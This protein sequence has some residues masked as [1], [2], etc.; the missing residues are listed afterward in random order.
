MYRIELKKR[1]KKTDKSAKG[2]YKYISRSELSNKDMVKSTDIE[3]TFSKVPKLFEEKV[4]NFWN[5]VDKNERK[6][7][8]VNSELLISIPREFDKEERI[9]LVDNLIKEILDKNTP[10][11]YAIH[12]PIASDGLHNPHCHLMIYEKNLNRSFFKENFSEDIDNK[13]FKG[14][15][16]KDENYIKKNLNYEK[17]SFIYDSREKFEEQLLTMS[18]STTKDEIINSLEISKELKEIGDKNKKINQKDY[19]QFIKAEQILMEKKRGNYMEEFK[20]IINNSDKIDIIKDFKT[21]IDNLDNTEFE[22]MMLLFSKEKEFFKDIRNL[23]EE[24]LVKKNYDDTIKEILSG[25]TDIKAIQNE[26]T[27][28]SKESDLLKI[29]KNIRETTNVTDITDKYIYDQVITQIFKGN[30]NENDDTNINVLNLDVPRYNEINFFL[31]NLKNEFQLN[32]KDYISETK[33]NISIDDNETSSS[34]EVGCKQLDKEKHE[35]ACINLEKGFNSKEKEFFSNDILR[36]QLRLFYYEFL[37]YSDENEENLEKE[38]SIGYTEFYNNLETNIANEYMELTKSFVYTNL[39]YKMD[40][41]YFSLKDEEDKDK[42]SKSNKKEK[43]TTL[44]NVDYDFLNPI[45]KKKNL[46][47]KSF[48]PDLSKKINENIIDLLDNEEKE[49]TNI[50]NNSLYK[51]SQR[52]DYVNKVKSILAK[53]VGY[54]NQ[55][56]EFYK[57]NI[58]NQALK[59]REKIL[60]TA[61]LVEEENGVRKN[62]INFKV[63]VKSNGKEQEKTYTDFVNDVIK[64]DKKNL[65]KNLNGTFIEKGSITDKKNFSDVLIKD[66]LRPNLPLLK[67]KKYLIK[68]VNFGNMREIK[69]ENKENLITL[70]NKKETYYQYKLKKN[71]FTS[72]SVL[73]TSYN[74]ALE[75]QSNINLNKDINHLILLSLDK[76]KDDRLVLSN[77]KL[78]KAKKYNL[79]DLKEIESFIGKVDKN[80]VLKIS[81]NISDKIYDKNY[82]HKELAKEFDTKKRI[83]EKVK[84]KDALSYMGYSD[85][86]EKINNTLKEFEYNDKK[87]LK[88]SKLK[89]FTDVNEM[90]KLNTLGTYKIN[91]NDENDENSDKKNKIN[92][93]EIIGKFFNWYTVKGYKISERVKNTDVNNFDTIITDKNLKSEN[94]NIKNF[95]FSVVI[96]KKNKVSITDDMKKFEEKKEEIYVYKKKEVLAFQLE[97]A[98]KNLSVANINGEE[99]QTLSEVDSLSKK[100]L[101]FMKKSIEK[102]NFDKSKSEEILDLEKNVIKYEENNKIKIEK[103]K[104]IE[105]DYYNDTSL[106]KLTEYVKQKKML[107]VSLEWEQTQTT[108]GKIE[109]KSKAI[110]FQGKDLY[111][112]NN[113]IFFDNPKMEDERLYFK[114]YIKEENND[115]KRIVDLNSYNRNINADNKRI[116]EKVEEKII[117]KYFTDKGFNTPIKKEEWTEDEKLDLGRRLDRE[118]KFWKDTKKQVTDDTSLLEITKKLIANSENYKSVFYGMEKQIGFETSLNNIGNTTIGGNFVEQIKNFIIEEPEFKKEIYRY[119][120]KAIQE[121]LEVEGLID[122]DL[123]LKRKVKEISFFKERKNLL[124]DAYNLGFIT[125]KNGIVMIKNDSGNSDK[126]VNKKISFE[127]GN[128]KINLEIEKIPTLDVKKKIKKKNMSIVKNNSEYINTLKEIEMSI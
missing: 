109:E 11:S 18:K 63:L 90:L 17:K 113:D 118:S 37:T 8:R 87:Y 54:L 84:E 78:E 64:N 9:K 30:E 5:S 27:L 105:E 12:N 106:A 61:F 123:K 26:E 50:G 38:K 2:S 67:V 69:L 48:M 55:D 36:K 58:F 83:N 72:P 31:K 42:E 115:N 95:L 45:T 22:K 120:N 101:A 76:T 14:T 66:N 82:I 121:H 4:S 59:D 122:D 73:E 32:F 88:K 117:K 127:Q 89:F 85:D 19:E 15:F 119:K 39:F 107:F 41:N 94:D 23:S 28:I 124:A 20:N 79:V 100:S 71:V 91:K 43:E 25:I 99:T 103:R 68:D 65:K 126:K 49:Y 128:S 112:Y 81:K 6:N 111:E 52:I 13:Y 110:S 102:G 98:T 86:I 108:E 92:N 80:N 125:D 44:T 1:N 16:K 57:S 93:L 77:I 46:H 116:D 56:T 29:D 96:D 7:G 75:L 24:E 62:R 70:G 21:T 34:Y 74:K 114:I 104:K 47:T 60:N 53:N 3:Y 51:T 35:V 33:L 10:Y 97:I 40:T